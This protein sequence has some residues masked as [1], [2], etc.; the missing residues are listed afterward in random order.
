[1]VLEGPFRRG[2]NTTSAANQ[3]PSASLPIGLYRKAL[4]ILADGLDL[5]LARR[6][7]EGLGSAQTFSFDIGA[8]TETYHTMLHLS[9]EHGDI[10]MQVSALN[11]LG[12]VRQ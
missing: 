8:A 6:T 4:E 10:P 11:K 3:P 1:M 7:Y 9:K 5:P 2:L 12:F